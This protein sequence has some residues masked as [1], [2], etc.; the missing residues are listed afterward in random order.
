V[1]PSLR[2]YFLHLLRYYALNRYPLRAFTLLSSALV[3]PRFDR[4]RFRPES[5]LVGE[6]SREPS[7]LLRTCLPINSDP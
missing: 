6:G 7:A 3:S 1:A 2:T 5:L 4:V